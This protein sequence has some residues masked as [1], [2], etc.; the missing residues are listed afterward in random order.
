MSTSLSEKTYVS[1]QDFLHDSF[2][3]AK[4]VL[5]SGFEPTFLVALWRG[6]S[7]VGM[8]FTEYF[9]YKKKPF[10]DHIA[11]RVSAY[12]H[13]QL[14]PDVTIYS[15]DDLV[16]RLKSSDK[17]LFV[18]DIIDSG[19]SLRAL[20]EKLTKECGQNTPQD[21]RI[22]TIYYKPEAIAQIPHQ[23]YCMHEA[24]NWIVFPHEIEGLTMEEIADNKGEIIAKTLS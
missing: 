2:L 18:D 14:K 8:V 16:K 1:P 10:R 7:P 19:N 23:V 4:K 21:I 17:L 6:G 3:L 22:A 20:L 5:D 9:N 15:L 13:D 11:I 12:S 24:K